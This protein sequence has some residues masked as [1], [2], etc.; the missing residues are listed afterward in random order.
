MSW[1]Q[2]TSGT[3]LSGSTE[4]TCT[5]LHGLLMLLMSS[6]CLQPRTTL[7]SSEA[8]RMSP[9]MQTALSAPSILPF[10]WMEATQIMLPSHKPNLTCA[11]SL[12]QRWKTSRWVLS[13][14]LPEKEERRSRVSFRISKASAARHYNRHG[15]KHT[16]TSDTAQRLPPQQLQSHAAFGMACQ[17]GHAVHRVT[18]Q[19]P[20]LHCQVCCQVGASIHR[21]EGSVR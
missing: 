9:A 7:I 8:W 4:P 1:E 6:I 10:P 15:R 21:L 13:S 2:S 3:G 12:T 19:G 5:A 16:N 17:C 14:L 18:K 20:Q 11:T